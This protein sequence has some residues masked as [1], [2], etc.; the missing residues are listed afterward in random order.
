MWKGGSAAPAVLLL[1][2]AWAG[3]HGD[4][5]TEPGSVARVPPTAA[6]GRD[7]AVAD[8]DEDGTEMVT[9]DGCA[10]QKGSHPLLLYEWTEGDVPLVGTR[11]DDGCTLTVELPLGRHLIVLTVTDEAGQ[12]AVDDLEV[13]VRSPR[14]VVAISSPGDRT[15]FATGAELKFRARVA[16][17][18]DRPLDGARIVWKSDLDGVLGTG[19]VVARS[20]LSRGAHVITVTATDM[21]GF[22]GTASIAVTIADPPRVRILSPADGS[23]CP[24]GGEIHLEG[25]CVDQNGEPVTGTGVHWE[26]DMWMGVERKYELAVDAACM[27]PGTQV[28]SLVCED[29]NG[30]TARTS[31]RVDYVL[32]FQFNIE[33]VLVDFGCTECHGSSRQEGGIRLDTHEA[34]TRG[35]NGNG[36][37]IVIGDA[38]GG[39][40]IPTLLARHHDP[41]PLTLT[42]PFYWGWVNP[43]VG[44]ERWW[45]EHMLAPWIDGGAPDN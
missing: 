40:L 7:L 14:P 6:A 27:G 34:L 19:A 18:H 28:I 31:I 29:A 24:V 3:C 15:A 16:D 12:S 37:L 38:A 41:D 43:A 36:P 39:I 33:A 22:V 5:V 1:A 32:S 23:A 45:V 17:W 11:G 35:G 26:P 30:L 42:T 10:S 25:E 20:D 4:S 8:L 13:G 21:S 9:L 2:V 44:V